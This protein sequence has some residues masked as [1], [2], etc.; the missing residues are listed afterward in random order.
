MRTVKEFANFSGF[1]RRS[2]V[3]KVT[4]FPA[5]DD[6][7]AILAKYPKLVVAMNHGP[8]AGP[9]AGSVGMM[10]QYY[11]FGGEERKPVVI[12]WRGFYKIPLIKHVVRFM[13]QVKN[14]PNLDGFVKRLTSG[15]AT[16]I[17]VMPEGEN[18]SFGNGLDIEPFLSPRFVE[19]AL[20]SGTPIL[21]AVH[22]GSE[23]WSNIVPVS[24]RLDPILRYLPRKSYERIKDTGQV[25]VSL[26]ALKRIPELKMYFKLYQPQ[27]TLVDLNKENSFELLKKESDQIRELMQAMVDEITGFAEEL[28][29]A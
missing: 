24:D 26:A 27:M 29:T 21:I 1:L 7:T 20:K 3:E 8:M 4:Q 6:L 28:Q 14:P 18:C 10:N 25:N 9:L 2:Y 11:K 15:D 13:S 16:D 12:A 17:F 23:L 19:L 22:V 5:S